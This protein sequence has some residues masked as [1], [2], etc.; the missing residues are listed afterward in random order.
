MSHSRP[1]EKTYAAELA[2]LIEMAS[3]R[4]TETV[5]RVL[6][7]AREM[8]GMD[9]AFIAEF[10]E[11][12]MVFRT[13]GGDAESYGWRKGASMPLEGTYCRGLVE[14]RLPSVV[15]DAGSDEHVKNLD[16]TREAD[17]SAYVGVPLRF[18]DG[19]LYGTLCALSHSPDPSLEERDLRFLRVLGSLVAEQL[20]YEELGRRT[21]ALRWRQPGCR[22]SWPPSRPATA[23]WE[24][25]RGTWRCSPRR[26]GG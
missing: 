12:R 22:R 14:G 20:E 16:I 3:E 18:S 8:L 10:A 7:A 11:E 15:S 2:G 25:T 1:Y 17:I 24:I 6:V 4:S 5:E 21:G 9:V 19:R 13:R 23:T 26:W